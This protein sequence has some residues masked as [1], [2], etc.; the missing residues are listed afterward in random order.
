MDGD[1]ICLVPGEFPLRYHERGV[2]IRPGTLKVIL[3]TND[4]KPL[5]ESLA[6]TL[7]RSASFWLLVVMTGVINLDLRGLDV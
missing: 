1:R 5:D 6:H 7:P 2:I 4:Y 3:L